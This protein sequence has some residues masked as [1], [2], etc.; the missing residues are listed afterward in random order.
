MEYMM[1]VLQ[2]CK[3]LKM[4]RGCSYAQCVGEL[5]NISMCVN[6]YVL[7]ISRPHMPRVLLKA[8]TI[9]EK[10]CPQIAVWHGLPP[11]ISDGRAIVTFTNSHPRLH[12]LE[13]VASECNEDFEAVM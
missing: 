3:S 10:I 1:S 12:E 5:L 8:H 7:L 13:I 2:L 9:S 6:V 4:V 11:C